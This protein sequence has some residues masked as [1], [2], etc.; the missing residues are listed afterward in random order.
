MNIDF[1]SIHILLENTKY[2]H[3]YSNLEKKS[4]WH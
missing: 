4:D 2:G 1:G 3:G